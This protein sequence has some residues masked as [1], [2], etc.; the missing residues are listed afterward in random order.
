MACLSHLLLKLWVLLLFL[1]IRSSAESLTK[2]FASII[3]FGDSLADTGNYIYINPDF[4]SNLFPYGETY[5]HH[6]NGR[7]S[8]GRLVID[9]IAQAFGLPLVPPYLP[10][11]SNGDFKRGVNFAV[12]GATALGSDFFEERGISRG[13]TNNSLGDQLH[14]FTQLLPSLCPA[15]SDCRNVFRSTLFL[16]G[17]IG[18]NDLNYP[19]AQGWSIKQLHSFLPQIVSTIKSAAEVLIEHGATTILVPGNLPIGCSPSY[20][21]LPWNSVRKHY[22]TET[23][24]LDNFNAFAEKYNQQ[25]K[26]ELDHLRALHSGVTLIYAD[27]YNAAMRVFRSPHEFGFNEALRACCGGGGH[28]NYNI[29]ALCGGPGSQECK[30]SSSFVSWDGIHLTEAMYNFVAEALLKGPYTEPSI[31]SEREG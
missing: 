3:S 24:C 18:G 12:S 13:V 2:C 1:P 26:M 17:E 16:L 27:Y 4:R 25:L 29:S 7:S 11:S 5:F 6:P 30:N 15:S 31:A 20:L 23:G 21:S 28:Y 22:N 8:D 10:N 19:F 14:W 9:F